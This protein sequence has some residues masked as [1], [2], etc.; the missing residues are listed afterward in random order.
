MHIKTIVTTLFLTLIFSTTIFAANENSM[1]QRQQ[2]VILNTSNHMADSDYQI[3]Q[4]YGTRNGES[5]T[6]LY[7]VTNKIQSRTYD[8]KGNVLPKIGQNPNITDVRIVCK[9]NGQ[10]VKPATTEY[11]DT[12]VTESLHE[13]EPK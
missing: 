13:G 9:H 3:I 8:E 11:L 4:L 6:L 1:V 12:V 10:E 5:D 7:T 2:T